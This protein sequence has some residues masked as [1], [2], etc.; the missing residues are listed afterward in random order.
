MSSNVIDKSDE[1][2]ERLYKAWL[3]DDKEAGWLVLGSEQY[4][5]VAKDDDSIL[6]IQTSGN[7]D[8]MYGS[9]SQGVPQ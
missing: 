8:S 9:Y 1:R 7:I 5:V 6:F 2:W 3:S 4:R